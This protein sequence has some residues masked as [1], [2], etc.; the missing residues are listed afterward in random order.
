MRK[1]TTG[2]RAASPHIIR[3]PRLHELVDAAD[4]RV[5]LLVAPAGYGKTTFAQEWASAGASAWYRCRPESTDAV[6]LANGLATALDPL[7]PG[8]H[9][10]VSQ[11]LER[12]AV[13]RVH[14]EA[15]TVFKEVARER[16]IRLVIDDYQLLAGALE[17]ETFIQ[18]ITETVDF[19]FVIASRSRP[20]WITARQVLYGEIAELGRS[21]LAMDPEEA[22][23][24]L[25]TGHGE[26]A[27]G[28]V[29]LAEGWPAVIGLAAS[30]S[31]LALPDEVVSGAV[32]DFVAEEVYRSLTSAQQSLLSQLALAPR[33]DAGVVGLLF[34]EGGL[35]EVSHLTHMG[36]LTQG[37]NDWDMHPLLRTFLLR[38]DV[39]RAGEAL[40]VATALTHHYLSTG[41]WDD[42]FAVADSHS[43]DEWKLRILDESLEAVLAAGRWATIERWVESVEA[44]A[45][46]E[47]IVQLARAECAFRRGDFV[48]AK[49]HGLRAS[50]APHARSDVRTRALTVAAQASYFTDDQEAKMLAE[51]ARESAESVNERR[52]ALWVEFLAICSRDLE[53]A[54]ACLEAF[55]SAG[56]MSVSDEVR[57]A[58]GRLILAERLGGVLDALTDALP[59]L[60][61]VAEVRDPMIRSSFYATLA[62]NQSCAARHLDAL[63]TLRLAEGEVMASSLDFA[64]RQLQIARVVSLIGLT[65]YG[66]A[67]KLLATVS[68]GT[69][70]DPYEAANH[71]IQA[72]RL[73]I[74]CRRPRDAN[75]V[76]RRLQT[77]GDEATEAE[78]LA[79]RALALAMDTGDSYTRT[80][81]VEARR[82]SPTIE[83]RVISHFAEA[84]VERGSD[85]AD[86]LLEAAMLAEQTGLRDGALFVLRASPSLLDLLADQR[87]PKL[88]SLLNALREADL[89]S[90][91]GQSGLSRR[92]REVY[93]LLLTGLTNREIANALYISEVTV[94]AHLRRI[95]SKLG[96][97]SRTEAVLAAADD[98]AAA[99]LAPKS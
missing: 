4:A 23:Q 17:S 99:A 36:L 52:S 57:L 24:V 93:E 77:I 46:A 56:S 73:Q 71:A 65:R 63:R 26:R 8:T 70:L 55:E 68:G 14:S 7:L 41:N 59:L 11:R 98:Q 35:P 30:A 22:R 60:P 87:E 40:A 81:A 44:L 62:R 34:P 1:T 33:I 25:A 45:G 21:V 72:A 2:E 92:E 31:R 6:A 61:V 39:A 74:A 80:L 94:K 19:T 13:S 91:Q 78:V 83:A 29:A 42:A 66:A 85:S 79:Y 54:R 64:I 49:R 95:F 3:R 69:P 53:A 47:P 50:G 10:A 82:L 5:I 97:R 86:R 27:P 28:L 9:S 18:E 58:A 12:G 75:D 76:L 96:V 90:S 37:I 48:L 20:S 32:Y 84:I 15:L 88:T 38:K 16:R 67:H 43:L 51:Q 89:E